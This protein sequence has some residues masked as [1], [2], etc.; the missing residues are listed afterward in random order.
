MDFFG[1]IFAAQPN[2]DD[3]SLEPLVIQIKALLAI[4][5]SL[6]NA[7]AVASANAMMGLPNE[8]T[9]E[10]QVNSLLS[11]LGVDPDA[12]RAAGEALGTQA[13][14]EAAKAAAERAAARKEAEVKK[15]A[16]EEKVRQEAEAAAARKAEAEA[17]MERMRLEMEAAKKAAEE[18]RAK[19]AEEEAAAKAA[20]AAATRK[21][22]EDAAAAKAKEDAVGS[23]SADAPTA[24]QPQQT[25]AAEEKKAKEEE[26]GAPA[27]FDGTVESQPPTP[28][29]MTAHVG[30]E[31]EIAR[32]ARLAKEE[33][34]RRAS[35]EEAMRFAAERRAARL[36]T[37]E[38][39]LEAKA[40]EKFKKK[41][42]E[43]RKQKQLRIAAENEQAKKSQ[44]Q[45]RRDERA[46]DAERIWRQ[47]SELKRSQSQKRLAEADHMSHPMWAAM[48]NAEEAEAKLAQLSDEHIRR[49]NGLMCG[50][51]AVGDA[52]VVAFMLNAGAEVTAATPRGETALMKAAKGQHTNSVAVL[53][54]AGASPRAA[55]ANGYTEPLCGFLAQMVKERP[56]LPLAGRHYLNTLELN[57]DLSC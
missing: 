56:D 16:E 12:A 9:P 44:A 20:E 32:R 31:D 46:A 43:T 23:T 50:A 42:A 45:R 54:A 1:R 26:A 30:S 35:A 21:A 52:E 5:M 14:T 38:G 19:A 15:A 8:G 4:D 47:K 37:R 18:A 22:A 17:E 36:M 6:S 34:D 40:A 11:S 55:Q 2:F 48:E 41:V 51:A 3:P 53:L 13:A 49:V 33:E 27:V 25:A 29:W 24:S 7:A 57:A 28:K 10:A 39:R